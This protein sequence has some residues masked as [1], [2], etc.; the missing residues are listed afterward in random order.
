VASGLSKESQEHQV[1]TL[2]YCLSKEA[3]DVLESTS[4]TRRNT[5]K[6]DAFFRVRKN[7]II[8]HM[9]FNHH[10]QLPEE[11]AEQFIAS[12]YYNLS[13]DC[14][15]GDLKNEMIRDRIVV[16]IRDMSLSE[17]LQMDPELTLEKA[18]VVVH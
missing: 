14:Q 10:F 3:E 8:E 6:F 11:P 9:K 2:L 7:V 17:R 16:S 15:Y 12:L 13:T 18:K 1:S 5:V 4:S